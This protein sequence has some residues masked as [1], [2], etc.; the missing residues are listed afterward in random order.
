MPSCW[1]IWSAPTGST[2]V[3][4]PATAPGGGDQGARPRPSEPDLDAVP[5]RQRLRSALREFYPAALVAFED[6]AHG[7]ALGVLGRAPTPSRAPT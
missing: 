7:D 1:P 3:G 5:T 2:T 4:S 6:L